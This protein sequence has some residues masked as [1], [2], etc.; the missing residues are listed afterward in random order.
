VRV[1]DSVRSLALSLA[2]P[3][4]ITVTV[5]IVL[6]DFAFG[7]RAPSQQ[8]DV[9]GFWL[10][11]HC[12][13]GRSLAAGNIPEW[14]PYV[15]AGVPLAADPQSGWMYLSAM[16][17]YTALPCAAAL[18]AFIVL[19][20]I[21]AGLGIYWFLRSE[22]LS[23]TA[24]TIGGLALSLG[25][26]ASQVAVSLPVS[27]SLAW[28]AILL[29]LT[30][31][32]FRARTWSSRLAWV[33][34]TAVAWGQLAAAHLSH[35][36]VL[37]TATAL[38]FGIIRA[39][40]EIR[41]GRLSARGALVLGGLLLAALVPVNLAFLVP[42]L[43]Y[44]PRAALWLGYDGLRE[45]TERLSGHSPPMV[46][47]TASGFSWPLKFATSPGAYLGAAVLVL[48]V[49]APWSRRHRPA[50]VG[51]MVVGALS[52]VFSLPAVA[53]ALS[54]PVRALPF[55][56]VYLHAPS[57]FRYGLLIVIPILAAAGLDAWRAAPPER[58]WRLAAP[59][60]VSWLLLPVL[61]GVEPRYLV[62]LWIGAAGA[63]ILLIAGATRPVLLL[64]LPVFLAVELS[65]GAFRGQA[66]RDKVYTAPDPASVAWQAPFEN[67]LEP[68]VDPSMYLQD[69]PIARAMDGG[70][71]RYLT[72]QP[73]EPAPSKG[74]VGRW[75]DDHAGL[76][77]NQRAMLFGL[78]DAQGYN[79]VQPVRYWSFSRRL[80]P[81]PPKYNV[82]V[83]PRPEDLVLDL[84]HVT[85][86][87][88]PDSAP[89]GFVPAVRQGPWTLHRGPPR[90]R[91]SLFGSWTVAPSAEVALTAV[92]SD[93]FDPMQN[94]VLE[95]DPGFAPAGGSGSVGASRYRALGPEEA[96]VVVD[97]PTPAV[98]LVR[99]GFDPNWRATVDGTDVPVIPA[100][101]LFQAV[102]VPAG[103]HVVRLTYHDP[104]IRAGMIGSAISLLALLGASVGARAVERR[105]GR[106]RPPVRATPYPEPAPARTRR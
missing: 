5:L 36:L 1:G 65:V 102:P 60:L 57:R 28:S 99:N 22:E 40:A 93:R 6:H 91:A 39:R 50:V 19:Q 94:V 96:M 41:A 104:S 17:L 2:G 52:Y 98:L 4:L 92:T 90:P 73:G 80:N 62:L 106:V 49:A 20:P 77:D 101:Y 7:G 34:L 29:A 87:V 53:R 86:I 63:A 15:M 32:V 23:R 89:E 59:G 30:S 37:G 14:N 27:G 35:G 69:G 103:R 68:D 64:V 44:L 82:T 71:G 13:L 21:M 26:A 88:G 11:H 3:T 24:A 75:D 25:M 48:S 56:D 76:L 55:G 66:A 61:V 8:N 38:L 81:R 47:P 105:Q 16:A 100:D 67:L 70:R 72:L 10:P 31:R 95:G 45:L 97:S 12:L 18:P 85:W 51:A 42:R 46:G 43:E 58:R 79:P 84:F 78:E 83:F 9:L 74:Y 33:A 54:S